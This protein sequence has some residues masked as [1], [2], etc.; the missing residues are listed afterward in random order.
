MSIELAA[1]AV[2]FLAP[3]LTEAGKAAAKTVGSKTADG[4]IALLGW[5][6]EK[7]TGRAKEALDDLEKNPD[8]QLN[9]DDVRT[10]LAKLLEQRP[11]LVPQLTHLLAERAAQ[12]D[13][14]T[15]TVGDGGKASQIKGNQNTVSIGGTVASRI[16]VVRGDFRALKRQAGH[17]SIL[18][19]WHGDHLLRQGRA[20]DV[21]T[22]ALVDHHDIGIR[23]NRPPVA[24]VQVRERLLIHKENGV[25]KPLHTG[26]Q[27]KRCGTYRVIAPHPSADSQDTLAA[28]GPKDEA[29]LDD[30]GEHQDANGLLPQGRGAAILRIQALQSRGCVLLDLRG[31]GCRQCLLGSE[32]SKACGG[33]A[34]AHG[35]TACGFHISVLPVAIA[36][37]GRKRIASR[38]SRSPSNSRF[39][40]GVGGA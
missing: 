18:A 23:A 13:V 2:G 9:Q 25:A 6:R 7:M 8:S 26:L 16:G 38:Q 33:G 15:Q 29:T 27:S 40:R 5:M 10:Q 39:N 11:E 31:V 34:G 12:G 1:A 24:L 28:F 35:M 19:K 14:L 3:Y 30:L 17:K 32:Q 21:G 4:A 20:A 22:R 37:R 36:V